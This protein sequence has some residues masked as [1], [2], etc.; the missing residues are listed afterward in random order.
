MPHNDHRLHQ[1]RSRPHV[2]LTEGHNKPLFT[3]SRRSLEHMP[4]HFRKVILERCLKGSPTG[5]N[6]CIRSRKPLFWIEN[7]RM[8]KTSTKKRVT[9]E[10][11]AAAVGVTKSTVSL[12]LANKGNFT[13]ARRQ[14]IW[15]AARQMNYVPNL[16]AQR[17]ATGRFE[18]MVALFTVSLDLNV[19][20]RKLQFL[21]TMLS[22]AGYEVPIYAYGDRSQAS[23][24]VKL[25]EAV[26]QQRPRAIL[27]NTGGIS[28]EAVE[29]MLRYQ[30]EGGIIVC[31]DESISL[32][33]DQ[34]HFD[35]E[36]N[37]YQVTRHLLELGHRDIAL[38]EPVDAT[39]SERYRG[40]VA[41]LGEYGLKPRLDWMLGGE[42]LPD[43]EPFSDVYE[44][45]GVFMAQRFLKL[46]SRPS[47]VV[48]M[49]DYTSVAFAAELQR[50]GI[51]VPEDVS[52]VSHDDSPIARCGPLQLTTVTHPVRAIAA[53]A[54]ELLKGRLDN[55]TA[56]IRKIEV[57]GE[58]MVRYSAI[59][60]CA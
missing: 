6:D 12:A 21:Q 10:D 32:N 53:G 39:H 7:N 33:C 8:N 19:G 46:A 56:P 26:C 24:Q 57:R 58:L 15:Q 54:V 51:R 28:G 16:H 18:R 48:L 1:E 52:I 30:E 55:P 27:C 37:T 45:D 11:V 20:T 50:A 2:I 36:D 44:E 3:S 42:L 43:A 29:V 22:N 59:P 47:A 41:A 35:R 31:Y 25:M 60:Y 40:Y 14:E 38:A 23:E 4:V 49:D 9:I 34:V 13:E 5:Y 17:L